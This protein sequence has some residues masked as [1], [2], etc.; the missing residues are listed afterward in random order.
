LLSCVHQSVFPEEDDSVKQFYSC[1]VQALLV[2]SFTLRINKPSS[3]ALKLYGKRE[4][5][6]LRWLLKLSLLSLF[7]C[8]CWISTQ[9]L[10]RGGLVAATVASGGW[11]G[12]FLIFAHIKA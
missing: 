1:E 2:P 11:Q 12:E 6:K 10:A 9:G 3:G 4:Y 5:I 7:G 8:C